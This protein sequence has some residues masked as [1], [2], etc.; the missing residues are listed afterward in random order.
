MNIFA[1]SSRP[2]SRCHD[3][4]SCIIGFLDRNKEFK[5]Y[6]MLTLKGNKMK[7][8]VL[9]KYAVGRYRNTYQ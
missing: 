9:K 3:K 1:E 5:E 4:T 6:K 8:I 7:L 2:L